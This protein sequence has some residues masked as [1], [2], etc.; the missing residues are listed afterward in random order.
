MVD[1]L[2]LNIA[3]DSLSKKVE[4]LEDRYTWLI[5]TISYHK[6][7]LTDFEKQLA[8]NRIE[9]GILI[10]ALEKLGVEHI[11]EDSD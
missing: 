2:N 5:N 1:K 7:S 3:I 10:S 6:K 11:V 9:K 8:V 4:A